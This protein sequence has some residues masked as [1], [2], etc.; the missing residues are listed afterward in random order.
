MHK[1]SGKYMGTSSKNQPNKIINNVQ[2]VGL[3]E[4]RLWILDT[5]QH[6]HTYWEEDQSKSI[7]DSQMTHKEDKIINF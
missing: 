7:L 2:I 5:G 1:R 6:W 4:E 3:K